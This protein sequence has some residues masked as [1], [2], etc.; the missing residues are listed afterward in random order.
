MT[1]GKRPV[2][3]PAGVGLWLSVPPCRS[4]VIKGDHETSCL[5]T[6]ISVSN[7][8]WHVTKLIDRNFYRHPGDANA[9]GLLHHHENDQPSGQVY[10]GGE[11]GLRSLATT[12]R[13]GTFELTGIA[14]KKLRVASAGVS[15]LH[16]TYNGIV[17]VSPG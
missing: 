10:R 1:Q 14:P 2:R 5:S 4:G 16:S 7:Q 13:L 12:A 11:R 15:H 9:R 8:G 3:E 17:H 6:R